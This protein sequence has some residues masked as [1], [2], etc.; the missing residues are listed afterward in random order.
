MFGYQVGYHEAIF[1]RFGSV[2]AAS[3]RVE[4]PRILGVSIMWAVR[5]SNP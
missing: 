1:D 2:G 3:N 5:D 4:T